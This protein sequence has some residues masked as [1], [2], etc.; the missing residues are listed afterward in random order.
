MDEKLDLQP[1]EEPLDLQPLDLQPINSQPTPAP[2]IGESIVGGLQ[3][4]F[5]LG[6]TPYIA[7]I[8][9]ALG[10]LSE[11]GSLSQ[12]A[13]AYSQAKAEERARQKSLQE[14]NPGP[15]L[16]GSIGGGLAV[17][18][19]K[20]KWLA[21]QGAISG[22]ASVE[23]LG[24]DA[25][26]GGVE[27]ALMGALGGKLGKGAEKFVGGAIDALTPMY[28]KLIEK[29]GIAKATGWLKTQ[30]GKL[31]ERAGGLERTPGQREAMASMLKVGK[32]EEGEIGQK[33][34]SEGV[35]EGWAPSSKTISERVGKLKGEAGEEIGNILKN[36]PDIDPE[37]LAS[38][39]QARADALPDRGTSRQLKKELSDIADTYRSQTL[40]PKPMSVSEVGAEKTAY[41]EKA[42]WKTPKTDMNVVAYE[43]MDKAI[44]ASMSPE[45]LAKYTEAKR[46]YE[47]LTPTESAAV[48][49]SVADAGKKLVSVGTLPALLAG[50]GYVEGGRGGATVGA[51]AGAAGYRFLQKRGATIG[52]KALW[53]PA[54]I[55]ERAPEKFKDVLQSALQRG[56]KAFATTQ[57]LLQSSD[58]EYR[59][60]LEEASKDFEKTFNP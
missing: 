17:P 33:L 56:E 16:A 26:L 38:A 27:G 13:E 30:A 36:Q 54:Q 43:E 20:P 40:P 18:G 29:V 19:S 9:G 57:F 4:G 60:S 59:Q 31:M 52:A 37:S 21:L 46:A 48:K 50:Y 28:N 5:T 41:G 2:S 53:T 11:T 47:L 58:P 8:S 12:A 23:D 1:I 44:K 49:Q 15:Y 22:A 25:I 39:I 14:A 7:G 32:V 55:I 3:S 6:T 45:D 42:N 10:N 34:L 51:L 24:P 35:A